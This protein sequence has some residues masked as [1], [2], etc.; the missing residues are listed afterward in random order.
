TD[1][2]PPL[3]STRRGREAPA[4]SPTPRGRCLTDESCASGHTGPAGRRPL[5]SMA[6][7]PRSDPP[8][9]PQRAVQRGSDRKR[10]FFADIDRH[11]YLDDLR[12]L[13]LELDCPVHAYVLM[14]NHVHLLLT[15]RQP[16]ALPR[17]M[18]ALGRRYVRYVNDR[19]LRTGTLWEGRYK[20]CLVD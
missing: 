12:P 9:P 19:Y 5:P 16:R 20:A 18:Q 17:L 11:R 2:V 7:R 13:A 3:R 1:L 10:C 8:G 4:P 15:P 6:R 14:T